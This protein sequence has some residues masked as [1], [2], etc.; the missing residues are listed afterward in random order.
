[1]VKNMPSSNHRRHPTMPQEHQAPRT[2]TTTLP[3]VTLFTDSLL[4]LRVSLLLAVLTLAG[5]LEELDH[6]L[7]NTNSGPPTSSSTPG[8]S[9][10]EPFTTSGQNESFPTSLDTTATILLQ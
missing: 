9:V 8:G 3:T 10:R 7:M 6:T 1:M 2:H 5:T 4:A